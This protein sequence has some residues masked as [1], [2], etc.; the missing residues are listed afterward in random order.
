MAAGQLMPDDTYVHRMND[1]ENNAA[2]PFDDI[3]LSG[4]V[5]PASTL[6]NLMPPLQVH[7]NLNYPYKNQP[8]RQTDSLTDSENDYPK[9]PTN[10]PNNIFPPTLSRRIEMAETRK[11]K[12][13]K[14]KKE[15]KA[16]NTTETDSEDE[17]TDIFR[18]KPAKRKPLESMCARSLELEHGW[19]QVL[20]PGLQ[21][22]HKAIITPRPPPTTTPT[23]TLTLHFSF[24]TF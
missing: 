22:L 2:F 11:K 9:E 18:T 10:G 1:M 4:N 20:F 21:I 14:K 17:K 15:N 7:M 24:S 12:K 19:K 3:I 8:D 13:K 23:P 6:Q 5:I 16:S